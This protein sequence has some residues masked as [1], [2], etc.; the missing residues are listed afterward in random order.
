MCRC[1]KM[2]VN[3]SDGEIIKLMVDK[4]KSLTEIIFKCE[5]YYLTPVE[6]AEVHQLIQQGEKVSEKYLLLDSL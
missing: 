1:F 4:L 2:Y 5:E 6:V 3:K